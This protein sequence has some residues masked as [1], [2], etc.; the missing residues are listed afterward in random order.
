MRFEEL[1]SRAGDAAARFGRRAERPAFSQVLAAQR[2][3][4]LVSAWSAAAVIALAFV[5]VVL[6]WPGSGAPVSPAAFAPTTTTLSTPT[7][8]VEG[9]V[10]AVI[11]GVPE[12][13][14]VTVPGDN[15]FTPPSEAPEGP[16]SVY[17]SVWYGTP[18][19]W[20]MV[21]PQGAVWRSL[22][23]GTDGRLGEKTFWWSESFSFSGEPSP[24]IT[25]TAELLDGPAL[26]VEAGGPGTNGSHPE[27]GDFMLVGLELPQPGCWELTA[28]Y[29]NATLGYVVW[30]DND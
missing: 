17:E 25:V 30:V 23:V 8:P 5:G 14:L 11:E 10:S 24:N 15:A 18:E 12:S 2:R 29:K 20:T 1:A 4:T 21:N 26:T 19:L 3:R 16:P 28:R 6:T 13:C 27:L 22:P 9:T 7:T